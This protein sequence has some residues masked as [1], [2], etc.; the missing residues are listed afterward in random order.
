MAYSDYGAFVY[1][2][3]VRQRELENAHPSFP[4]YRLDTVH[5]II[6]DEHIEVLCYK[7]GLPRIY[8]DHRELENYE[9][10]RDCWDYD[11]FDYEHKGY[12]FHF[13]SCEPPYVVKVTT[14]NGDKWECD[15]D[16]MYGAGFEE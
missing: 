7:Q 15:Y 13:V 4:P 9:G 14:P 16:Y 6:R 12:K 11:E 10:N 2:N 8:Y 5:G 3:G 1:K